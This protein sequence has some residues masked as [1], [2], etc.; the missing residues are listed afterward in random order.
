VLIRF[1]PD[2]WLLKTLKFDRSSQ[3]LRYQLAH[4][5]D[6][7]GR[8]EAA[9]TLGEK[10]EQENI[11][12]LITALNNDAFWGVSSAAA[13]ALASIGNEQAQ[14]ALIKALTDLDPKQYSRLRA[15]I[16]SVLGKFQ[17]PQQAEL[18][19][20]SATALRS[21]LEAGDVSYRVESAAAEALGKTHSEGSV[22]LLVKL[23]ERPS[24]VNLVQGGIFR[25]LGATGDDRVVDIIAS[26]V[27]NA[28][29]HPTLRRAAASGLLSV[30]NNRHIYSEEARQRA[31]TALSHAIEHD[32]WPPVR[33]MATF[34][35]AALGE[36]RAIPL[37]EHAV[38]PELDDG[39][40]RVMRVA[41]FTLQNSDKSDEQLRQLRK[42]LDE[43]REENRQ[44]RE[45]LGS[46][47][48]RMK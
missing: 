18:A 41:A 47:E 9:E 42:D 37:L 21:L 6:T 43:L 19:Q 45:Q 44:L 35:L 25:G 26:Y 29:N 11:E 7:L 2:G 12:A 36:K 24:W 28:S 34:A 13:Q 40:Q 38:I 10:S 5:P 14:D 15:T 17:A 32:T 20:R 16:A 48:V 31:V 1:D 46:L 33:S 30:G 8:I 27:N 23:I 22:D 39:V 4:D 3:L